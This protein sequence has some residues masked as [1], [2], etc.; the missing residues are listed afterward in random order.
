MRFDTGVLYQPTSG[1]LLADRAVT[2]LQSLA[3]RYGAVFRPRR[4]A[5]SLRIVHGGDGIADGVVDVDTGELTLRARHVVITAGP[6]APALVS[7]LFDLPQLTVTQEQPRIFAPRSDGAQWPSFVHWRQAADLVGA[8][9]GVFEEHRGVKVGLH[10]TGK[11]VDPDER[12][13]QPEPKADAALL[14]YVAD[15]L[16]GL[17]PNRSTPISCLYDTTPRDTFVID[18]VGPITVAVGFCGQGFK[19]A[20]LVGQYVTDLVTIGS[21]AP[22]KYRLVAHAS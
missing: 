20:P 8:G 3:S 2:V 19:F 18:R 15:W 10:R 22:L 21:P 6:W 14:L 7:G 11:V 1:R 5:A 17:D 12:D 9:Y 13:F 4:P 16:P